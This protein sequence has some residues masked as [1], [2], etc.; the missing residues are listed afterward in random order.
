MKK[1]KGAIFDLDGTVLD[2][3]Y[4]WP[5]IDKNFLAKRKIALPDDYVKAIAAMGFH[6]IAIYTKNRF[7]LTET[8]DEIKTEWMDMSVKAYET[9][10]G[11]KPGAKELLKLLKDNSV[12]ISVAT[13]SNEILFAPA[14]K[15]NGVY[16]YFDEFT[17]LAE[18]E[19]GKGSSDIYFKAAEKIGVAVDECVVFED[20]YDGLKAARKDG[21]FT[22]GIY[23]K[24]AVTSE[25]EIRKESDIYIKDFYELLANKRFTDMLKGLN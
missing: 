12:K 14:L 25:E 6:E 19:K 23:E 3:M 18:V 1:I 24:D 20:L 9:V 22:I 17:T 21:F 13:A 4:I 15:N 10:I 7:S 16:E 2:S 11:L 5:E 8:L